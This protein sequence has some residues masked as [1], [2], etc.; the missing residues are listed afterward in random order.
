[1]GKGYFFKQPKLFLACS[2]TTMSKI[3]SNNQINDLLRSAKAVMH[4]VQAVIQFLMFLE[5]KTGQNIGDMV[6]AAHSS[7]AIKWD[8]MG[9]C[10]VDNASN[11]TKS[12]EVVEIS[13]S[14]GRSQPFIA[15]TCTAHKANTTSD[16][17]SGTSK[18]KQILI[19]N[20]EWH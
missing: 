12:T 3:K 9:G 6:E 20:W 15:G 2:D 1:M 14:D 5:K 8:Y 13:T 19:R 18:H 4:R 7:V 10:N 11:A 16:Q 17:G